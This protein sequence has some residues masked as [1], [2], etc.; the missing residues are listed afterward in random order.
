VA[1]A[2]L[3]AGRRSREC[4]E[5]EA[6]FRD[7][8]DNAPVAYHEIGR[9]GVIRQVIR[10]E[11]VLLGFE[12]GQMVGGRY[13]SSSPRLTGR[14]VARPFAGN[15]PEICPWR[16]PAPLRPARRW[17]AAARN[18]RQPGAERDGRDRRNP[19]RPAGHH[20]R[21]RAGQ[22]LRESEDRYRSLFEQSGDSILLLELCDGPPLILDANQATLRS[23]GY[24]LR[25][26]WAS[27]SL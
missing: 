5:S 24:S 8:F 14:P 25:S 17:R 18:P 11:C 4:W 1:L 9:D 6:T 15:C 21:Q 16:R 26:W 2:A 23:Y 13:G 3:V 22:A 19:L 20:E 10:A 12:T 27:R 7:L